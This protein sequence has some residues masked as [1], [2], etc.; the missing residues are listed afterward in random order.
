MEKGRATKQRVIAEAAR[1]FNQRGF[2]G[3]SLSEL[4]EATGLKKGGIY[5]HFAGKEELA[6]EAFDHASEVVER[7]RFEGIDPD[8]G[9]VEKLKQFVTNF[10]R[11][12]SPIAGGCPI[13]NTAVDC[14]DGNPHLRARA[15]DALQSWL[16]RL[17]EIVREGKAAGEIAAHVDPDG[18]AVLLLCSLE[19]ALTGA[20]LLGDGGPLAA[21]E[22]HLH[23]VLD[24]SVTRPVNSG[25][26]AS[27]RS[28]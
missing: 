4:M 21:I 8:S 18:L 13:W 5:R 25:G 23:A 19:G 27:R 3:A 15:K 26:R 16:G 24:D 14:D 10:A 7:L 2:A 28:R 1:V 11:L 17:A 12:R 20:R 22:S 9:S 6:L